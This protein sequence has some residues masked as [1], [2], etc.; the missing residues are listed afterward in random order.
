MMLTFP[1]WLLGADYMFCCLVML[2]CHAAITEYFEFVEV[3]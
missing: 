3:V 2:P 1:T